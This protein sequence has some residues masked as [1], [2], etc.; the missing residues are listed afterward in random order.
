MKKSF[1][2]LAFLLVVPCFVSAAEVPKKYMY[3]RDVKVPAFQTLREFF[4]LPDRAGNYEITLVSDTMGP[5]TFKVIAT[6]GEHETLEKQHRSFDL[7]DHEFHTPFPNLDGSRDVI[8]E[9]ANSNPAST[10]TVSVYVVEL[11]R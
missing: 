2:I 10:A 4:D 8:V 11:P 5:L 7:K 6:N 3:Y 9:I 1:A